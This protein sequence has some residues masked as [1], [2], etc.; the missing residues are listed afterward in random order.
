MHDF[1]VAVGGRSG[2]PLSYIPDSPSV[3]PIQAVRQSKLLRIAQRTAKGSERRNARVR[4]LVLAVLFLFLTLPAVILA[5]RIPQ[6]GYHPRVMRLFNGR[7]HR[8]PEQSD[9]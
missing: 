8:E 2:A 3:P 7:L 4:G 6:A 5:R 1:R 9:G